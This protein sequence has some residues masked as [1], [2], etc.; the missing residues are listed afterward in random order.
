MNIQIA[1]AVAWW[2]DLQPD[3]A[4]NRTGNRAAIVRLRRC[5]TVAEAMCDQATIAL[6][7]HCGATNPGDL[8][9]VGLAAAV[10]VHVRENDPTAPRLARHIGPAITDKPETALMTPLRFIR[11]MKADKPDERLAAFRQLTVLAGGSVNVA[12]LAV[13]LLCWDEEL[14]RRWIY[15]YWNAG[16]PMTSVSYAEA[17]SL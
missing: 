15:D 14:Q 1:G 11:L 7:R 3:S 10:L 2:R 5:T 12:D 13:A 17:P 9:T 4:L 16:E 6:F 8:P